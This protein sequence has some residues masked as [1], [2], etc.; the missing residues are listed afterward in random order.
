ML[1]LREFWVT[2]PVSH[3]WELEFHSALLFWNSLLCSVPVMVLS[4]VFPVPTS[5]KA[6]TDASWLTWEISWVRARLS[7]QPN[8]FW[9][10]LNTLAALPAHVPG[11]WLGP[12]WLSRLGKLCQHLSC[13]LT[14]LNWNLCGWAVDLWVRSVQ[15]VSLLWRVLSPNIW[16]H[17]SC[18]DADLPWQFVPKVSLAGSISR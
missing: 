12:L 5:L 6:P 17:H 1:R 9:C 11:L 8:Q 15:S 18:R 13:D 7:F 10:F 3:S 14:V 4:T 2:C 16:P